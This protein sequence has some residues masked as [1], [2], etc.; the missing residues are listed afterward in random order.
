[1]S[2]SVLVRV[3][4][5]HGDSLCCGT[6]HR[7]IFFSFILQVIFSS[8]F[9]W[10][11]FFTSVIFLIALLCF[12][13]MLILYIFH[14]ISVAHSNISVLF[15]IKHDYY[16][17]NR[18]VSGIKITFILL[19]GLNKSIFFQNIFRKRY[20]QNIFN[21]FFYVHDNNLQWLRNRVVTVNLP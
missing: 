3:I 18:L 5:A 1:M 11:I 17:L 9:L 15:T 2:V 14:L 12:I 20:Y 4:H 8:T 19:S 6:R 21:T 10:L 7:Y 16:M 13:S